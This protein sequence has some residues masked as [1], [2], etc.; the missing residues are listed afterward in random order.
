[1]EMQKKTQE[2]Q[3]AN[4]EA[5]AGAGG[6]GGGG[7][8]S[9]VYD[10]HTNAQQ[11]AQQMLAMDESSRRMQLNQI[12]QQDDTLYGLVKMYMERIRTQMSSQAGQQA[13]Q[14]GLMQTQ[15][16]GVTGPMPPGSPPMPGPGM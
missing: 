3:M 16:G 6:P 4:Q 5:D 15:A 7:G 8:G 2:A 9:S 14:Q 11:I 13:L 12:S 1:M 10:V